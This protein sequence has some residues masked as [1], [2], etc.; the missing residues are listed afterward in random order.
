MANDG[1]LC[2]Q[3]RNPAC[4]TFLQ[5][6]REVKVSV[7]HAPLLCITSCFSGETGPSTGQGSWWAAPPA[8]LSDAPTASLSSSDGWQVCACAQIKRMAVCRQGG[9]LCAQVGPN[10]QQCW[11]PPRQRGCGTDVYMTVEI[12]L[13]CPGM[14][15]PGV[16]GGVLLAERLH[17][18]TAPS[19][20]CRCYQARS[21]NLLK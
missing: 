21:K 11:G 18:V 16:R 20:G 4:L 1:G 19:T 8:E 13:R 2:C 17:G 5:R 14:R 15:S 10:E 3:T 6:A 9:G 12:R 7:T